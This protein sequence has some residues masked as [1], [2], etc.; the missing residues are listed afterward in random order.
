[1]VEGRLETWEVL[2]EGLN[3]MFRTY[4]RGV[5]IQPVSLLPQLTKPV[6]R[7]YRAQTI[8]IKISRLSGHRWDSQIGRQFSPVSVFVT[9]GVLQK[10]IMLLLYA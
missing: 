9:G 7:T 4:V 2:L 10:L 8:H 5:N 3:D 1:M 6:Y